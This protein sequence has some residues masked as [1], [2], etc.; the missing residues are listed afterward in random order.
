MSNQGQELAWWYSALF[1]GGT[2]L[3]L[4]GAALQQDCIGALRPNDRH[5]SPY[6]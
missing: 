5:A 3:W 4:L 2:G 1:P 6:H